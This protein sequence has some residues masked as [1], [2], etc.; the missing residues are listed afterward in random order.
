MIE[1]RV[2]PVS[3]SLTSIG[4]RARPGQREC[5]GSC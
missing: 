5:L 2:K 1:E 4:A 3:V